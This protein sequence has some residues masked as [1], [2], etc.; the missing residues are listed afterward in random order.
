[1]ARASSILGSGGLFHKLANK[2]EIRVL[3]ERVH[4]CQ[5]RVMWCDG[6]VVIE[7]R[8]LCRQGPKFVSPNLQDDEWS[9]WHTGVTEKPN[10][11][12]SIMHRYPFRQFFCVLCRN[13][14]VANQITV[15]RSICCCMS[16]TSTFT[17][18]SSLWRLWLA[19]L[20]RWQVSMSM[21]YQSHLLLVLLTYLLVSERVLVPYSS[22][23]LGRGRGGG[24]NSWC[25]TSTS[26]FN[27]F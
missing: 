2:N 16:A 17:W 1:M 26:R 10:V 4:H 13:L 21:Y 24:P 9:W 14:S 11:D 12:F 8:I 5:G 19:R 20:T 27:T 22:S 23:V 15:F 3:R 25:H 7:R 18:N 6:M